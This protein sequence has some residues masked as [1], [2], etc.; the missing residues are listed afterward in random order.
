MA[1]WFVKWYLWGEYRSSK[2]LASF[3]EMDIMIPQRNSP[4]KA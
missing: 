2:T 1:S 3:L 4:E